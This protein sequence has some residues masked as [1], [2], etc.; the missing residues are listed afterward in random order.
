MKEKECNSSIDLLE[1]YRNY[2]FSIQERAEFGSTYGDSDELIEM[3]EK[4]LEENN[5]KVLKFKSI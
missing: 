5:I 3:Y 4:K 1:T 2:L